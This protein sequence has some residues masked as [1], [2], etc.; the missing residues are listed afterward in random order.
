MVQEVRIRLCKFSPI[1]EYGLGKLLGSVP[2][3]QVIADRGVTRP[4]HVDIVCAASADAGTVVRLSSRARVLVMTDSSDAEEAQRYF[5]AGALGCVSASAPLRTVVEAVQRVARGQR[6][7][8]PDFGVPTPVGP[9]GNE[10][11]SPRETEVLSH[12]ANGRTHDQI[13][14]TMGISRHTV[15]TYV[16][17]VRKKLSLGNKAEL[18]RAAISTQL[19][20]SRAR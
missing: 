19:A 17:R 2:G 6:F 16:K 10:E 14:R 12:I 18:T 1:I 5:L 4:G 20:L 3:F 15:D 11:L 13:A 9:V 7:L 8:A